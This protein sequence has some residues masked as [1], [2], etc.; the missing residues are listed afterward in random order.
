MGLLIVPA[1]F[2]L[3]QDFMAIGDL[4]PASAL[5]AIVTLL[6]PIGMFATIIRVIRNRDRSG[7]VLAHGI[8][9]ICVLQ[10][11]VILAAAGMLPLRLWA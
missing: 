10:W 5:L 3:A 4:T 11:C 6:L 7:I 2:F 1:P 9:A 8:A